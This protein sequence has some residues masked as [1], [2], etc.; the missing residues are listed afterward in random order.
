MVRG[1]FVV[2]VQLVW[3]GGVEMKH[4]PA[5]DI[6]VGPDHTLEDLAVAIDLAFARWDLNHMHGFE[7]PDGTQF[8]DP[9]P[10]DPAVIDAD[11][12]RAGRVVSRDERFK[13]VFDYGANWQHECVVVRSNVKPLEVAG[14]VPRQPV[15]VWGWGWIPDQY[16]RRWDGD[17]GEDE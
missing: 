16:G 6:L 9:D 1:W 11:T 3:G 8:G 15:P 5:R 17:T 14:I 4:P 7:F 10:E 12:V 13:Y 2:R